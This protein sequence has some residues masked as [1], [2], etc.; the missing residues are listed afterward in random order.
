MK[1]MKLGKGMPLTLD[2][3]FN[4]VFFCTFFHLFRVN[5]TI[6]KAIW[7]LDNSVVAVKRLK[8]EK[9]IMEI[10]K[11]ELS[12]MEML[13]HK[14]V[15]FYR[16]SFIHDNYLWV[17][18]VFFSIIYHRCNFSGFYFASLVLANIQDCNGVL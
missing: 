3:T 13:E 7:K 2:N 5:G 17:S 15:V 1:L 8:I 14:N 9:K 4:L 11:K 6:F 18:L 10:L 16:M 12:I